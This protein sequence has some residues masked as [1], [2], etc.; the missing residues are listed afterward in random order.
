M[1]NVGSQQDPVSNNENVNPTPKPDN[2]PEQ[3]TT[4]SNKKIHPYEA[5]GYVMEPDDWDAISIIYLSSET[6]L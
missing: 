1:K 3:S 4:K 6:K 2:E 5:L